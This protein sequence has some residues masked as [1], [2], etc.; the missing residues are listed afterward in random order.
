VQVSNIPAKFAIPFA[1]SAGVGYTRVIPAASQIGFTPGAASLTD[2]FPPLNFIPVGSGGIPPFG[3]DANG[4]LNQS[5]GW[6]RWFSAGGPVQ[7]DSTFSATWGG[8][9]AGSVVQSTVTVG[10]FW[11][12]TVDNNTSNPDTGGAGWIGYSPLGSST[13]EI[14]ASGSFVTNVSDGVIGLNRTTSLAT[15]TTA[16]P[17]GAVQGKTIT[18]EDIAGNFNAYP[19]TISGGGAT[20]SGLSEANVD[21]QRITF[22]YYGSSINI[23]TSGIAT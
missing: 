14:T 21:Y 15:S 20:I 7:W 5:T 9:P 23:W 6:D 11:F 17:T 8:Y 16:L 12:C 1:N 13:R 3:Q 10:L 4:L 22:R 2:G 18:Y 19:L